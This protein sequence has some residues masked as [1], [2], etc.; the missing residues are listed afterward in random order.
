V[1][2]SVWK[3]GAN[4]K[5]AVGVLGIEAAAEQGCALAHPDQ[6]VA[7]VRP[8]GAP[9]GRRVGDRE[10]QCGLTECEFD[11]GLARS[12]A[13]GVGE[14]FLQ[15]SVGGLIGGAVEWLGLALSGDA[16][17]QARGAVAGDQRVE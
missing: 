11:R 2:A 4:P 3:A 17:V 13:A 16:D 14:C 15:D 7:A 6:P 8:R 1:R 10:L 12:V 5:G 9:A